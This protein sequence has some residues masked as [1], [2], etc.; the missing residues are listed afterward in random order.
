MCSILHRFVLIIPITLGN[1]ENHG[2][3]SWG[4]N[5]SL[6]FEF[7]QLWNRHQGNYKPR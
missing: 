4:I 1:Y 2:L 6:T 7:L 3:C 5:N